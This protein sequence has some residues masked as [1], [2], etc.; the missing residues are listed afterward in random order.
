MAVLPLSRPTGFVSWNPTNAD[1]APG[2]ELAAFGIEAQRNWLTKG[3]K[4][5][6]DETLTAM[7]YTQGYVPASRLATS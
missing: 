6:F 1:I 2:Q 7:G 3:A 4:A 5:L